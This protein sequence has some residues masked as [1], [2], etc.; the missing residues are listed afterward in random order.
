MTSSDSLAPAIDANVTTYGALKTGAITR[1]AL[2][3]NGA[4]FGAFGAAALAFPGLAS[5]ATPGVSHGSEQIG[6]IYEL[7][8]AFHRAKSHQDIDLMASLWAEDC[9]FNNAGTIYRGRDAVRAFF[10]TTG[11][12]SHQRISFVP[13]FKDQIEV[14]GDTAFLYFECHDV[15]LSSGTVVTHLFNAGTIRKVGD[16]WL[17][18]DMHGGLAPLSVDTIYS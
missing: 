16:H 17:F 14:N 13:S 5:A 11:S 7:Q 9:T 4:L 8:A 1:R 2:L 12:W 15:D 18:Q 6:E 10:L 3:R